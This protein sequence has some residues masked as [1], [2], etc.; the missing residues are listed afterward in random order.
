MNFS[1]VSISNGELLDKITIL[2]IKSEKTNNDY[3]HKELNDLIQ[4]AKDH[5]IY[6]E[7]YLNELSKVNQKLWVIEDRLREL[8]KVKK[9]DD[10]FI[11]LARE[12]YINNDKRAEIKRK[13]NQETESDYQEV[14]LYS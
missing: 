8:E 6:K 7:S 13:I 1:L 10:E 11:N 12:V 14:K 3:V 2:Q 9:F 4:I 5:N